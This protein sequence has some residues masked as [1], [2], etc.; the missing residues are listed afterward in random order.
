[1]RKG[2]G[3]GKIAVM[4]VSQGS[5]GVRTRAKT[6]ALV[7]Q[8]RVLAG[9]RSGSSTHPQTSASDTFHTSYLELR[10]RKL[11][12]VV[13]EIEKSVRSH[14]SGDGSLIEDCRSSLEAGITGT[15]ELVCTARSEGEELPLPVHAEVVGS[16]PT[17]NLSPRYVD[18]FRIFKDFPIESAV[19]IQR[20]SLD[21]AQLR[22]SESGAAGEDSVRS[23][24]VLPERS[25]EGCLEHTALLHGG[26]SVI[27][28]GLSQDGINHGR[29][30]VSEQEPFTAMKLH[31]S[32]LYVLATRDMN[33]VDTSALF[34]ILKSGARL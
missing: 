14:C 26:M 16:S 27:D 24:N 25:G 22:C 31:G 5:L 18:G 13:K 21:G 12:K 3:A 7:E 8:D 30:E 4:E 34:E 29:S 28:D 33:L 11:E 10:S 19:S 1:M 15:E 32:V 20:A 23:G 9:A 2:K 17:P 6:L